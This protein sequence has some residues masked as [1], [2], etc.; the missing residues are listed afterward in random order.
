MPQAALRGD[1]LFN[2]LAFQL[3]Q[4]L[5]SFAIFFSVLGYFTS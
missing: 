4:R 3:S 2:A 1:F 5:G